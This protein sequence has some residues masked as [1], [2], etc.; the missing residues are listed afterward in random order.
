MDYKN[1]SLNQLDNW[2]HDAMQCDDLTP[3]E[4]Y[5]SIVKCVEE[6]V[7]YHHDK[8]NRAVE[9]LSLLR[10][11]S[12]VGICSITDDECNEPIVLNNREFNL[13]EANYYDMRARLD[14]EH[15]QKFPKVEN[16]DWDAFWNDV[17][18]FEFD[19]ILKREG[20]EYTP[21]TYPDRY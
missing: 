20:Y 8:L 21:P 9:F 12:N 7:N 14:A 10:G 17:G 16:K 18:A 13:R 15:D 6:D 19:E 11:E 5:D 2:I 1:Y 3:Q 4:I